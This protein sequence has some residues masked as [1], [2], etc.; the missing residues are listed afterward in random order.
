MILG[1]IAVGMVGVAFA[2]VP[3]YRLFCQVTG[4][5]G[6]PKIGSEAVAA[7]VSTEIMTIR[8]DA[9]VNKDLP[10]TF[11]PTENHI[12]IPIGET[13]ITEYEARN[14]GDTPIIGTATFNVTPLKAASYFVKMEC[15]CFTEQKLAPGETARLPVAFYV[16]PEILDDPYVQE[17]KTITLSYTFF[18]ENDG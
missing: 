18:E 5:A 4:Y 1:G 13:R 14:N 6:T 7:T 10:W 2:A 17:V 9:N 8:F 12:Q 3:A 16:D 15:F 11:H